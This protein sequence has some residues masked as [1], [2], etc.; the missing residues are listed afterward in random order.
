MEARHLDAGR[1]LLDHQLIDRDGWLCGNVDDIE[2]SE[3]AAG[4]LPV[5][6]GLLVGTGALAERVGG[7]IGRGWAVLRRRLHPPDDGLSP[8]SMRDVA[9]VGSA[10]HLTVTRDQLESDAFERW[11]RDRVVGLIPGARHAPE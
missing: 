7:R 11:V 5:V 8:I 2:L 10:I 3:P 6:T 9:D 4:E 1:E